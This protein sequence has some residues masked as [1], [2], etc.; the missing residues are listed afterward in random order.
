MKKF[1]ILVLM[2]VLVYCKKE[3][4]LINDGTRLWRPDPT[5]KIDDGL[6]TVNWWNYILNEQTSSSDQFVDPDYFDI[7]IS[8]D[9]LKSFSKAIQIK[10]DNKYDYTFT[11]LINNSVYYFYVIAKKDGYLPLYSDTIMF[12]PNPKLPCDTLVKF[13]YHHSIVSVSYSTPMQKIAYVD[14]FYRWDG[15]QN[16]CMAASVIISS[17]HNQNS[18]LL[19]INSDDPD[20]SPDGNKIVFHTEKGGSSEI[21]LYDILTKSIVK[22]TNDGYRNSDP[23]FSSD[24]IKILY[25]SLKDYSDSNYADIWL[26]DINTMNK[27][28]ITN[29]SSNN[30]IAAN[31]PNWIS[32]NE[33]IFQGTKTNYKTNIFISSV[34]LKNIVPLF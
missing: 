14:L 21:A 27:V 29:V 33:F 6:V 1:S 8:K 2:L 11:N 3:T 15:G 10:N 9:N 28:Q 26:M 31:S 23:D 12:V 19:D 32:E 16:C 20:W 25:R 4:S 24:G 18:E 30:L 5:S 13:D 17:L 22:L 7:Y 34:I